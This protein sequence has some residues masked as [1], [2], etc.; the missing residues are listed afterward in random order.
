MLNKLPISILFIGI[1][2]GGAPGARAPPPQPA[3]KG[4]SAPTARTM[5]VHAVIGLTMK[6]IEFQE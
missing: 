4:A 2:T 6:Y 5:P 1:G 3:R